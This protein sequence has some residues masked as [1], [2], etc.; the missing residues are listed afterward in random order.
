[1]NYAMSFIRPIDPELEDVI[2]EIATSNK[3]R[4][5]VQRGKEM[6]SQLKFYE[7][8][9]HT[10]GTDT[11]D[12][13]LQRVDDGSNNMSMGV[14]EEEEELKR[15]RT[16]MERF[17]SGL[18]E[19]SRQREAA[20]IMENELSITQY[21]VEP[22][23]EKVMTDF[24]VKPYA[25]PRDLSILPKQ[26]IPPIINYYDNDD[27]FWSEYIQNKQQRWAA[28]PMIVNRPLLKH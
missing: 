5:N 24:H 2:V 8:D 20:Q 22:E 4:M 18:D 21:Q 28:N 3:I 7:I 12:E 16:A 25:D 10:L 13:E 6:I 14:D 27:G 17:A 9:D 26:V 1:M 11:E 23:M 19:D 15:Q